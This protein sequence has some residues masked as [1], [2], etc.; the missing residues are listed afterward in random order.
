MIARLVPDRSL[1]IENL[2]RVECQGAVVPLGIRQ[3]GNRIEDPFVDGL[4]RTDCHH[5]VLMLMMLRHEFLL[6]RVL[7]SNPA[8]ILQTFISVKGGGKL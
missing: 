7:R 4:A 5:D 6:E 1:Y 3:T 2:E 8:S